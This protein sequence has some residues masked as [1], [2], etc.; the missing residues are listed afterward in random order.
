M[1][2]QGF[3]QEKWLPIVGYEGLYEVS[4]MGRV[5]S[6]ER[7][8][9][10]PYS[11]YTKKEQIVSQHMGAE[12]Y[13]R[14]TLCANGKTSHFLVHRLVASAFIPNPKNKPQIDHIDGSRTNNCVDNLRWVSAK[15]NAM[16][17]I[18]RKR[19]LDSRKFGPEHHSFGKPKSDAVKAKMSKTIREKGFTDEQLRIR[20][21][22]S[23]NGRKARG[24]EHGRARKIDQFSLTG[25][26]IRT[27]GC[28]SDAARFLGKRREAI[29]MN[30]TGRT[31]TAFGFIWKYSPINNNNNA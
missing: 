15:E 28:V 18:T 21:I 31:K 3:E 9:K 17:P 10:T 5:R 19:I 6:V 25:E 7:V 4:N 2:Q 16:N 24:S 13:F 1:E 22:N 20:S 23:K 27:W 8:V 12:G 30:L 26:F 29:S 14:V 11:S